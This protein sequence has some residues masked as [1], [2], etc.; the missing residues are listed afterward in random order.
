MTGFTGLRFR[1][2]FSGIRENGTIQMIRIPQE[3]CPEQHARD[4]IRTQE[5][6]RD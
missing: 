2:F 4:G 1:V 6:L 3:K 5:L